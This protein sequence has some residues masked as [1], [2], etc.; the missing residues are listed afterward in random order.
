VSSLGPHR[1]VPGC[2][3]VVGPTEEGVVGPAVHECCR[4]ATDPLGVVVGV[5]DVGVVEELEGHAPYW[6]GAVHF[7]FG[8]PVATPVGI[9][10]P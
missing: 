8:P 2:E 10:Q 4:Q 7:G 1:E 9:E 5:L 3:H 6:D